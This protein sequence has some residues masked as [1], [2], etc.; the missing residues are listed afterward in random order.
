MATSSVLV[1]LNSRRRLIDDEGVDGGTDTAD[2][3]PAESRRGDRD[4][5]RLP[6]GGDAA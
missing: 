1:V 6:T 4:A 2:G 5:T 3:G